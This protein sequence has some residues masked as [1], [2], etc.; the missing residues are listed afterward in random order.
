MH[1]VNY[2]KIQNIFLKITH[3]KLKFQKMGRNFFAVNFFFVLNFFL[4]LRKKFF[5]RLRNQNRSLVFYFP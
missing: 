1:M 5:E 2:E 4:R 3:Q